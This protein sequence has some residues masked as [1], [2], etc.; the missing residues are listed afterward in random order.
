VRRVRKNT[1]RCFSAEVS[2]QRGAPSR[3][4][5][6]G[7]FWIEFLALLPEERELR[8]LF[9]DALRHPFFVRSAGEGG[10]LL[11]QITEVVPDYGYA[12]VDL[13]EAW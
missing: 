13:R 11:D 7:I 5:R 2:A 9:G 10:G 3:G 4:V 12:I 1:T 6:S 8:L